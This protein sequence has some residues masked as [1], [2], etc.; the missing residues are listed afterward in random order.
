LSRRVEESRPHPH[1]RGDPVAVTDRETQIPEEPLRLRRWVHVRVN[2]HV[3]TF[4]ER[5][6]LLDQEPIVD[7]RRSRP[8][9]RTQRGTDAGGPVP[10]RT[11]AV[12]AR[13]FPSVRSNL[14]ARAQAG[15]VARSAPTSPPRLR[16]SRASANKSPS[17]SPSTSR[18]PTRSPEP[19]PEDRRRGW[20]SANGE[21]TRAVGDRRY[22]PARRSPRMGI[23]IAPGPPLSRSRRS[24][25]EA[26][27]RLTIIAALARRR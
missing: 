1:G 2:G 26:S 11:R 19:T 21:R 12:A 13:P 15:R 16:S 10:R 20:P 6:D 22:D 25:S 8:R 7:P 27:S 5:R 3:V 17:R 14:L 9:T 23:A 4:T 24:F 18:A